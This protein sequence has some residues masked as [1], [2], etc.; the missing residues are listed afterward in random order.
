MHEDCD[1][2][3]HDFRVHLRVDYIVEIHAMSTKQ[4]KE[5]AEEM[6]ANGAYDLGEY[7]EAI[8]AWLESDA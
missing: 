5:Q 7:A 4:A 2:P 6:A 3:Q 8:E 1:D